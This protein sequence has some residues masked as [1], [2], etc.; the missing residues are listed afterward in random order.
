MK[1]HHRVLDPQ[2]RD[3]V[4]AGLTALAVMTKAPRAG[5][6]KTRLSP[7][8]SPEEAASLNVCFLRDT[9]TAIGQAAHGKNGQGVAVYTPAG[10]DGAYAGILPE[11][12]VL[13]PQRG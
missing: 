5:Q 7:P 10:A 12:F 8:L 13:V 4:A 1:A 9:V 2:R 11:D 3:G 6:V